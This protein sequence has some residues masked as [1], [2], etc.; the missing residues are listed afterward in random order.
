MHTP[1]HN[2]SASAEWVYVYRAVGDSARQTIMQRVKPG[3][4]KAVH[5]RTGRR[6]GLRIQP[7]PTQ[8]GLF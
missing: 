6:K 2:H 5:V 4:L 7:P 8:E 1:V 3:E